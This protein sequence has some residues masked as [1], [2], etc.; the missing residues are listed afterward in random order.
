MRVLFGKVG[1][2]FRSPTQRLQELK[3]KK[4]MR[5]GEKRQ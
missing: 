3:E 5:E 1:S 4:K 2:C